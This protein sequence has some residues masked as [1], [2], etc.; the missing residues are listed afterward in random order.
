MKYRFIPA[1]LAAVAALSFAGAPLAADSKAAAPKPAASAASS[2]NPASPGSAASAATKGGH[3][4]ARVANK[5]APPPASK[6]VDI[7]SATAKELKKL[8][9][10]KDAEAAKIIAGRPYASKAWL[11]SKDIVDAP[12]YEA[13][14]PL[15]IAKQPYKDAASNAALYTDKASKK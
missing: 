8:P 4:S 11:V 15:I 13:I 14:K 3:K 5:P 1:T 10:I 2:A 7:N 12:T 9:G 6:L